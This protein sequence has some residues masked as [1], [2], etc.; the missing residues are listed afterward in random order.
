M[1]E[2]QE[3]VA[4]ALE[5]DRR[6]LNLAGDTTCGRKMAEREVDAATRGEE[7]R[8]REGRASCVPATLCL[9]GEK[10]EPRRAGQPMRP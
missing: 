8:S 6:H 1:E 2:G 3:A 9:R 4:D 5:S 7:A 10:G